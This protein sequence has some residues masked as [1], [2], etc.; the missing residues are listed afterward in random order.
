MLVAA[1]QAYQKSR[2]MTTS[3]H[4]ESGCTRL[5]CK[6]QS[7]D[8]RGKY[9]SHHHRPCDGKECKPYGPP[10][11]QIIEIFK[12]NDGTRNIIPLLVMTN[13]E[14]EEPQF[15]LRRFDPDSSDKPS[16]VTISHVWSDGWGN[17]KE[18]KLNRCQLEFIRRQIGLA[19]GGKDN[20]P[21]WMDT[22]VVPVADEDK[23]SRR[24]A[25]RQ[26]FDVFGQSENT[27]ILD[28]G[29]SSMNKGGP[30]A[31]AAMKIFSSVWMRRLW[32]LQEAYLSNKIYIPFEEGSDGTNNLV[33]FEDIEKKLEEH[34]KTPK[35]GITQTIRIQL[36]RMIIGE[37]RRKWKS[38]RGANGTAIDNMFKRNYAMLVA[39]TYRAARWRVSTSCLFYL[40][41]PVLR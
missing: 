41:C 22:L 40:P 16:F 5:E 38:W 31:E 37:E 15:E 23:E 24:K 35:S 33:T 1:Y 11:E 12:E 18:N 13:K 36:S 4:R 27:I 25:I 21:F 39:N 9:K 3:E 28:N 20:T 19:T 26:I 2:R 8:V 17:E 10:M 30:V 6:V 14:K 7:K 29:L 32:T 34:M